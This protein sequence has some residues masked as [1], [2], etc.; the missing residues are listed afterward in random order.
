MLASEASEKLSAETAELLAAGLPQIPD[1]APV[2]REPG[3]SWEVIPI[4]RRLAY[5]GSSSH[6]QLQAMDMGSIWYSPP[7]ESPGIP[8]EEKIEAFGAESL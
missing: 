5:W 2:Q 6:R 3:R 4:I 7:E 8:I 1:K